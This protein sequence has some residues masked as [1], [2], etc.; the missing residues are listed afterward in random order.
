MSKKES[1]RERIESAE[2]ML[3][4]YSSK[5]KNAKRHF[6]EGKDFYR[7]AF[8]RDRDRIIYSSAFRRLQYKTQVFLI[9]EAD[10]YRTRLTHTIEVMQHARTLARTLKVNEDL[11]E[12]IALAHDIGHTPFGHAGEAELCELMKAN[13]GFNHNLQGLRIV[14]KLEKRYVDFDGLNLTW[15]VREG[16]ARHLT[17][18]D[19]F[20]SPKEFLRFPQPSIEAQIVSVADELAFLAHDLDDGLRVGLITDDIL[21]ESGNLLWKKVFTKAKKEVGSQNKELIYRRS[22]RHLIEY[23]NVKV[24]TQTYEN[25]QKKKVNS[26]LD[27]RKLSHPIVGFAKDEIEDFNQLRNILEKEM[28]Q[29]PNV[30]LMIE[31]GREIIRRLFNKFKDKRELLPINVQERIRKNKKEELIYI[32]DYISGMTDRYAMDIYDMIFQPHMKILSQIGR[33]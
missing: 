15:E 29:H 18:Y 2:D 32:S 24:L 33:R 12:V 22:V 13:G 31:K 10:F 17:A 28:Y 27:I 20:T 30:L 25:L 16:I 8:Q 5:S 19:K 9:D 7:S 21:N 23:C 26:C 6:K 1:I 3:A 14:D 4:S 11:V